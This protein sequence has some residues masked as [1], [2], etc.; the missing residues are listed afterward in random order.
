MIHCSLNSPG[1]CLK[2]IDT[3]RR[4]KVKSRCNPTAALGTVQRTLGG[5]PKC[6]SGEMESAS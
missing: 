4:L 1:R 3:L 2:I 6:V 5:V